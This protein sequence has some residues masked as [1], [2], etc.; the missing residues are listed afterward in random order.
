MSLWLIV[1]DTVEIP[2]IVPSYSPLF[3]SGKSQATNKYPQILTTFPYNYS[4]VRGKFNPSISEAKAST[5]S[6]FP[7]VSLSAL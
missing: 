2:L 5:P 3:Y 4:K 7:A 6:L 1:L